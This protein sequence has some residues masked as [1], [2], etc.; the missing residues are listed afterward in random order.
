MWQHDIARSTL[1]KIGTRT[2]D[3]FDV[4]MEMTVDFAGYTGSDRNPAMLVR[5]HARVPFTG[6]MVVPENLTP[7]PNS[8]SE[9]SKAVADYLDTRLLKYPERRARAFRMEPCLAP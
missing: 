7:A 9:V 5:G 4:A 6:V 1:L 3:R 8:P 2:G